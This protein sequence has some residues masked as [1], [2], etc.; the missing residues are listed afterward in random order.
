M[1][2]LEREQGRELAET[3]EEHI[4]RLEGLRTEARDAEAAKVGTA[5]KRGLCR[6]R[7]SSMQAR[8][9]GLNL[10]IPLTSQAKAV[11]ELKP[12]EGQLGAKRN[13]LNELDEAIAAKKQELNELQ[14]EIEEAG[15]DMKRLQTAQV[16]VL[17]V[18]REENGR[19]R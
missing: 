11:E 16:G 9:I 15:A 5:E 17:T 13:A 8:G 14:S 1:S 19:G 12:I 18:G 6:R 4:R 2:A 7:T 3:R 10:A